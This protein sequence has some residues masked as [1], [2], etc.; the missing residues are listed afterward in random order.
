MA[1]TN[2]NF[3]Q[4]AGFRLVINRVKY[5]NLQY[6]VQSVDHP[7]VSN[8]PA[9]G[10]YSRIQAVDQIGDKLE[11]GEVTF[12]VM[13]DEEMSA[14]TEMYN[15]M[16]RLTRQKYTSPTDETDDVLSSEHDISLLILNSSNVQQKRITYKSAFPTNLGQITMESTAAE[17]TPISVPVTFRYTYFSIS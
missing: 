12:S 9:S 4:P 7:S 15:W 2:T 11:F 3:L 13:L 14:Y 10:S 17:P 1:V 5:P 16:E 6:F 8:A